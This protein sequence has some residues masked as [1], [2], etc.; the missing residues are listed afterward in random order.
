MVVM[1]NNVLY[2]S[3]VAGKGRCTPSDM[4]AMK[5]LMMMVFHCLDKVRKVRL[6]REVS[7]KQK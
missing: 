6:S 4:Q 3:P 2:V 5:P 1:C 7:Y